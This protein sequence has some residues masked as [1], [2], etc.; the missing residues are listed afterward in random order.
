MRLKRSQLKIAEISQRKTGEPLKRNS[1]EV[2]HSKN[3][4]MDLWKVE[5]LGAYGFVFPQP[6]YLWTDISP[7]SVLS[8]YG[9]VGFH[10]L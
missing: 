7:C 3:Y 8:L 5:G 10:C 4:K 6:C 1:A 2:E 9:H